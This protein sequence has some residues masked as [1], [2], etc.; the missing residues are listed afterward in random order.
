VTRLNIVEPSDSTF[1]CC[2]RLNVSDEI[3]RVTLTRVAVDRAIEIRDYFFQ[4]RSTIEG[5]TV[6]DNSAGFTY[7]V[8]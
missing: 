8:D 5:Q 3:V 7:I 6:L 4:L 1:E 2:G